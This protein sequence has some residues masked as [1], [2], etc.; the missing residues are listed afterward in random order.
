MRIH[1]PFAILTVTYILS[2]LV[3]PWWI[4]NETLKHLWNPYSLLHIPLYGILMFLLS[5][6]LAA[7]PHNL[8]ELP[9][10]RPSLFRA[11]A[12]AFFTGILDELNQSFIPGREASMRDL[13]LDLAGI[14]LTGLVL[15]FWRRRGRA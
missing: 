1:R 7:H 8:K 9:F 11:G 2:I 12:I 14:V 4:S 3:L 6:T 10:D 13:S 15:S 5:V